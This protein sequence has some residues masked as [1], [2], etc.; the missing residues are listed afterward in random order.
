MKVR[1]LPALSISSP[2]KTLIMVTGVLPTSTTV[3]RRVVPESGG[4][5]PLNRENSVHP[6]ISEAVSP[7]DLRP[8]QTLNVLHRANSPI[9]FSKTVSTRGKTDP[10]I[11]EPN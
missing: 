3:R 7:T 11:W 5:S 8:K 2:T 10:Y 4:H 9:S 1:E 6:V